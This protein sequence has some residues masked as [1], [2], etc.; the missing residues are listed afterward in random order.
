MK[1]LIVGDREINR[2][3]PRGTFQAEG[4]DTLEA[5][6]LRSLPKPFTQ[7]GLARKVR[8]VLDLSAGVHAQIPPQRLAFIESQVRKI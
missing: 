1:I 4:L 2:K 8:E 6:V 7:D 5:S 3:L